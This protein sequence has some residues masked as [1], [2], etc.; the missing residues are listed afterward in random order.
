M[1]SVF[2]SLLKHSS[3]LLVVVTLIVTAK[4]PKTLERRVCLGSQLKDNSSS[5]CPG[6]RSLR[7]VVTTSGKETMN[8]ATV[9]GVSPLFVSGIIA[10]GMVV[11]TVRLDIYHFS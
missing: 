8:N 11:P 2:L 5:C 1:L 6:S 9:C 10:H 4:Y 3:K 7:K